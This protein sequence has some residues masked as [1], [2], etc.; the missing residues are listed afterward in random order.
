MPWTRPSLETMTI[1][2]LLLPRHIIRVFFH[3]IPLFILITVLLDLLN[4]AVCYIHSVQR[5]ALK[6]LNVEARTVM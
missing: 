6:L 3:S 2:V 5:Y 4:A 1:H